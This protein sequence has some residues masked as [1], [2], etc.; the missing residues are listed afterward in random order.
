MDKQLE[1]LQ[2]TL[3]MLILKG[4][5]L[6]P[7]HGYGVLLRIQLVAKDELNLRPARAQPYGTAQCGPACRVVWQERV[8]DHSPYADWPRRDRKGLSVRPAE[9]SAIKCGGWSSCARRLDIF[10]QER[11]GSLLQTARVVLHA[12]QQMS[13]L[14]NQLLCPVLG[15]GFSV[16][17]GSLQQRQDFRR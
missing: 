2:G 1:L 14:L 7:L 4:V 15:N 10:R 13:R 11:R 5:S 16:E 3:D 12:R 17:F 6:E 9:T 8:G